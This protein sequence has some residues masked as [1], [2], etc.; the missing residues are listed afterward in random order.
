MTNETERVP[1]VSGGSMRMNSPPGSEWYGSARSYVAAPAAAL[2]RSA[3]GVPV[4][5][6]DGG[7]GGDDTCGDGG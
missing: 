3:G 1:P 4:V 2:G 7:A 5:L 6:G